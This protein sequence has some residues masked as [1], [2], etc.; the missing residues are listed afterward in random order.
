[1]KL[2]DLRRQLQ[3]ART[4]PAMLT[5]RTK[6]AK[7]KV[8]GLDRGVRVN[9]ENRIVIGP[10]PK[11]GGKRR[12]APRNG[13]MIE[14]HCDPCRMM[15][16][17]S[18]HNCS[19]CK[20]TP[21]PARGDICDECKDTVEAAGARRYVWASA[22]DK[23]VPA[24]VRAAFKV[25]PVEDAL[26]AADRA[27]AIVASTHALRQLATHT[28][29][30]CGE[31]LILRE[32]SDDTKRASHAYTH[33]KSCP[34]CGSRKVA[35]VTKSGRDNR[36]KLELEGKLRARVTELEKLIERTKRST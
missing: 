25:G 33:A 20:T 19:E 9:K 12:P 3:S 29:L 23:R 22:K 27:D 13:S 1:M 11:C 17:G 16:R 26:D 10:C 35:P 6:K 24:S 7:N 5:K 8:K 4:Q 31:L 28:C 14:V 18:P 15:W 2:D 21:V 30:R 34:K 32:S 36:A